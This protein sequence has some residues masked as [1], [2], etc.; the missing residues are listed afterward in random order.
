MD[1]VILLAAALVLG[2]LFERLGQSALIGYLLAGTLVGPGVLGL[3][4]HGEVIEGIAELGVA[5]LLFVIGLEFS[6]RRL[7]VVGA[8]A[9][10][11][12]LLQIALTAGLVA[13]AARAL[14]LEWSIALA[15]GLITAP[16]STACVM[17]MLNDRAELETVHGRVALGILLLQDAAFVVLIVLI[18]VLAGSGSLGQAIGRISISLGLGAALIGGFVVLTNLIMP[19]LFTATAI[20]RNRELPLL[21]AVTTCLGAAWTAYALG[22]SPVL[23]AFVAGMLLA[24]SPY[25][26]W[27]RADVSALRTLFVTLFFASIG[28]LG[29]LPWVAQHWLWLVIAVPA[30]L[31]AKAIIIVASTMLFRLSLRGAVAVGLCLA[32]TGEFSIVL[33]NY[34]SGNQLLDHDALRLVVATTVLTLLLTP[35]LVAAAPRLGRWVS[36]RWGRFDASSPDGRVADISRE[37]WRD[38][39]VVI[40]CGPAG[41]NVL[42]ALQMTGV[43]LVAADLNPRTLQWAREAQIPT[44]VGDAS[45]EA[46][47]TELHVTAAR[48]VVV[49]VPDHRAA[50]AIVSLARSLTPGVRVFARARYHRFAGQLE[51][52]GAQLVDEESLTGRQ[53]GQK[54]IADLGLSP[55][56]DDALPPDD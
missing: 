15:L 28:M 51:H 19:R 21:L 17:R 14:G 56:A 52:A 50:V 45:Q 48:A 1:L 31:T 46:V 2:L 27:I 37:A 32:Q 13:V 24:E 11:G 47:L 49:T 53:L 34:A 33:A 38:H 4:R 6:F 8:V 44:L 55:P 18:A 20:A 5:L 26:T 7:R 42:E 23:G 3:V 39:V 10:G 12:G 22:L 16:S 36:R 25:A 29:D 43:S 35:Y 9:I 41:R 40:G 30:V 54:V